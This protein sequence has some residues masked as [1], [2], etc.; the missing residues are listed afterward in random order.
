MSYRPGTGRKLQLQRQSQD[1]RVRYKDAA[2]EEHWLLLGEMMNAIGTMV[3]QTAGVLHNA[4]RWTGG[5]TPRSDGTTLV[6]CRVPPDDLDGG[7]PTTQ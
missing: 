3:T 2:G 5:S 7:D 6:S 4:D 1:R